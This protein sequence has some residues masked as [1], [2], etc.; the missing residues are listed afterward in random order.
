MNKIKQLVFGAFVVVG[1]GVLA[2]PVPVGAVNAIDDTC[3]DPL[4]KNTVICKSKD[5]SV[6]DVIGA[7]VNT[8][9]FL[10][11]IAAVIVIIIGGITYT[12]SAGNDANVKRAKDMILYAVIGLVI[13][14]AAYAIVNWVVKAFG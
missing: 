10:L 9:L 1:L 14:F 5:D 12:T 6:K 8:L 2:M 13:A 11:G 7:V 3:A 4:N